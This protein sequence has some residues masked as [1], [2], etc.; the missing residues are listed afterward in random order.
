MPGVNTVTTRRTELHPLQNPEQKQHSQ[1]MPTA[2]DPQRTPETDGPS[3][4]NISLLQAPVW[5]WEIAL[6]FWF[7]GISGGSY[8]LGRMADR[9]GGGK[10][11]DLA[12]LGSYISFAS[13]LPSPP[14]LIYDLGDPKRFHHMLRVFKPSTPMSLGS[15][16]LSGYSLPCTAEVMRHLAMDWLM[17]AEQRRAFEASVANKAVTAVNDVAG[18]PL[19][20]GLAGYTGVLLSGASTPLRQVTISASSPSRVRTSFSA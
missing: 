4:Y 15:W 8:V 1:L 14:L 7:G 6:Y 16:I 11:R 17:T 10:Y 2:Q 3:Y 20:L 12:K 5:K 13:L 19:A 9:F 18:V